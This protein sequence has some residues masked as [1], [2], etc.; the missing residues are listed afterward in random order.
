MVPA[1]VSRSGRARMRFAAFPAPFVH[2]CRIAPRLRSSPLACR[3][4]SV[5]CLHARTIPRARRRRSGG[6]GRRDRAAGRRERRREDHSAPAAARGCCHC[7]RDSAEVLG[8]DLAVDRRAMRRSLAL[9]GHETFCYDD[10]TV[11][12]NIRFA[13]RAAGRS[14]ADADAALERLGLGRAARV[15][16]SR[17]SQGQRRRVA[18][19]IAL[20]RD[21]RLLLLDE[22][23]AGLDEQGRVRAR[24]GRAGRAVRRSHRAARVARARRGP[25]GRNARD[26]DRGGSGARGAGEP[27]AGPSPGRRRGH[28]LLQ[29]G[30]AGRGQGSSDRAALSRRAR[31]D[32]PVRRHRGGD[33]RVRA[34]RRPHVAAGRGAGTV[35]GG[36]LPRGPARDRALLHG[37]GGERRPRRAA[38]LGPRRRRHLRRQGR[39][40]S[41]SSCSCWKWCSARR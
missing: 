35:L 32:P 37:R 16:H 2:S 31:A 33:V 4:P 40:P 15:T 1:G 22:P 13:T 6:R 34:R 38:P 24:R 9:V 26:P 18:L 8:V 19:A 36:G 7:D 5:G 25:A 27:R 12:E 23:H 14:V 11:Q 28:D 20:A 30:D 10:L 3:A 21:P 17:L 39:S 29:G 41:R